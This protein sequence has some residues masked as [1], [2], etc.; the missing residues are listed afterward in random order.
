MTSRIEIVKRAASA[1]GTLISSLDDNADIAD[2]VNQHY[3]AVAAD[4]LTKHGWRFARQAFPMTALET[5]PELPW[6]QAWQMPVLMLALQ[7][8][9]DENGRRVPHEARVTDNG[10]S[11]VVM[12]EFDSLTAVGTARVSE[13]VWPA[14]FARAVQYYMEAVF[15]RGISFQTT[16]ADRREADAEGLLKQAKTRDKNS[17]TPTDPTEWDLTMARRRDRAWSVTR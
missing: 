1:T 16:A 9:C 13:S 3:E 6:A 17:S 2:L 5:T 15:L 7:Y 4:A 10:A 8:V 14:D 12:D 11:V